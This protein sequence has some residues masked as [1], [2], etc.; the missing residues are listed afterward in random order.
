[1]NALPGPKIT[2][3]IPP[4]RAIDPRPP[5]STSRLGDRLIRAS[6]LVYYLE[7]DEFSMWRWSLRRKDG[8]VVAVG[9][10]AFVDRTECVDSIMLNKSSQHAAVVEQP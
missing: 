6:D 5:K 8:S 4:H 3:S 10:R 2:V 9:G 7:T 1:M